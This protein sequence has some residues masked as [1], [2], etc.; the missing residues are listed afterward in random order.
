LPRFGGFLAFRCSASFVIFSV[1][2]LLVILLLPLIFFFF[3]L[4]SFVKLDG[5][6]VAGGW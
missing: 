1:F 6:E 4:M 2:F 5:A 3:F